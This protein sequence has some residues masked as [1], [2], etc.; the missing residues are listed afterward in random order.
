MF[1]LVE[2]IN[3][4]CASPFHCDINHPMDK[5]AIRPDSPESC[6]STD[7]SGISTEASSN[8]NVRYGFEVQPARLPNYEVRDIDIVS[9]RGKGSLHH[10]GNTQFLTVLRSKLESYV[11]KSKKLD[12]SVLIADIVKEIRKGGSRFV[13]F[14]PVSQC[15]W[16]IGDD[17]ARR[18]TGHA[19]RDLLVAASK[20]VKTRHKGEKMGR[21]SNNIN[22]KRAVD[23]KYITDG[24][25]KTK[26]RKKSQSSKSKIVG[27]S[28]GDQ[29][30][31]RAN[32]SPTAAL[33]EASLPVPTPTKSSDI[34][35]PGSSPFSVGKQQPESSKNVFVGCGADVTSHI[36]MSQRTTLERGDPGRMKHDSSFRS[37]LFQNQNCTNGA[38]LSKIHNGTMEVPIV[39]SLNIAQQLNML[40]SFHQYL[41]GVGQPQRHV[42]NFNPYNQSAI[43]IGNHDA[44]NIGTRAFDIV[45][46][47]NNGGRRVVSSDPMIALAPRSSSHLHPHSQLLNMGNLY[48]AQ[49]LEPT[50][51]PPRPDLLFCD[52]FA[53]TD[54]A[55]RPRQLDHV[56]PNMFPDDHGTTGG[57]QDGQRGNDDN[58]PYPFELPDDL[59]EWFSFPKIV[60]T[61]EL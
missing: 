12:K 24:Q 37:I 52:D 36:A 19:V 30:L 1:C 59:P 42:T 43:T 26:Q 58:E 50:P 7:S 39:G 27:L 13:K 57:D 29:T 18:K 3:K 41:I 17:K 25:R 33:D 23:S 15:W 22:G 28:G 61:D 35:I 48:C 46:T 4:T 5:K 16:E 53:V 51:L 8:T 56:A 21:V 44:D 45:Q 49:E 20:P 11:M 2:S 47:T 31:G 34:L 32:G 40:N 14:D 38:P 6:R 10:S 55:N 9:G 54:V 60:D